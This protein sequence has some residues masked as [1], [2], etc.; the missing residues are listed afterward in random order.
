MSSSGVF[1]FPTERFFLV[2]FLRLFQCCWLEFVKGS[3]FHMRQ[4]IRKSI[5]IERQ[6]LLFSRALW[7][8]STVIQAKTHHPLVHSLRYS[9]DSTV[10]PRTHFENCERNVILN[11]IEMTKRYQISS[12]CIVLITTKIR[13][14]RDE[15]QET[16]NERK[17]LKSWPQQ[18]MYQNC[19]IYF[20][21]Q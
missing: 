20:C 2:Y 17:R 21:S 16:E 13:I 6:F 5:H 8:T 10:I 14:T 7:M 4:W 11:Q 12:S 9:T 18:N 1:F 3:P 19:Q 15:I